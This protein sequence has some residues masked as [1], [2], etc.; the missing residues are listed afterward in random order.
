LRILSVGA[1]DPA[2]A[3]RFSVHHDLSIARTRD[4]DSPP[5][6]YSEFFGVMVQCSMK[7]Y[8][9]NANSAS[10]GKISLDYAFPS[11]KLDA[12]EAARFAIFKRHTQFAQSVEPVGHESFAARLIDGAA[13]TIGHDHIESVLARSN[14]SGK[15][16]GTSTDYE[17]VR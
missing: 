15:S 13:S 11:Y 2:A 14:G 1:D 3:N 7:Q 9:A 17:Y 6:A 16:R 8:T 4:S 5:G 12:A 10:S